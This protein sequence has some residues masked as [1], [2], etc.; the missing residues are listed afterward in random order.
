[1]IKNDTMKLYHFILLFF[2][3]TSAGLHSAENSGWQFSL[4]PLFGIKSGTIGEYVF[5]KDSSYSSNKL[6]YLEW[7]LKPRIT[8]GT[9]INAGWNRIRGSVYITGTVPGNSGIMK[10]SD[11]LNSDCTNAA[12]YQYK[13]NYSESDNILKS[14]INTGIQAG[15]SFAL[16]QKID[17]FPFAAFDFEYLQFDAG[18][19]TY[20]YGNDRASNSGSSA[21]GLSGPYYP[22]SDTEHRT[23]RTMT[24][25]VIRYTQYSSYTWLG[26]ATIIRLPRKCNLTVTIQGSPFVYC[27]AQD[28]HYLTG[29]TYV[30]VMSGFFSAYR[31]AA[32]LSYPVTER[33]QIILSGEYFLLNTITGKSYETD[34]G[35]VL[36]SSQQ[37]GTDEQYGAITLSWK[38]CIW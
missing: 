26:V 32:A 2:L 5:L 28:D 11:W 17:I 14:N 29:K 23:V 36:L 16:S 8:A 35:T 15:Y 21:D 27:Q 18:E 24:G 30:D 6:S 1:M 22:S 20:W 31:A 38:I 9:R 33:S 7:E 3:I 34:S 10:D 37:G 4:E 12:A 19:G 25:K 13:T